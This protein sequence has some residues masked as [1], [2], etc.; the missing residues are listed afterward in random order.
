VSYS[1]TSNAS[2]FSPLMYHPRGAPAWS[3][4]GV[5]SGCHALLVT[6]VVSVAALRA[7]GRSFTWYSSIVSPHP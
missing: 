7:A 2:E 4:T 5:A 6:M 3:G 1:T